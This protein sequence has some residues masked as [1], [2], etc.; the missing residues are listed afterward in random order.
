M[1]LQQPV[2][3]EY[4]ERMPSPGVLAMIYFLVFIAGMAF[5]LISSSGAS[6]P[7]P[8]DPLRKR[9]I[10]ILNILLAFVRNHSFFFGRHYHWV[11]TQHS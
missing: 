3:L 5:L 10:S 9:S 7:T 1:E 11:F 6:Y 8:Y 4:K 2:Y